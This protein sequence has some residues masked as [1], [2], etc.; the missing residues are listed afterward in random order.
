MNDDLIEINSSNNRNIIVSIIS[1]ISEKTGLTITTSAIVKNFSAIICFLENEGSLMYHK[2]IQRKEI[3]KNFRD[4]I[5]ALK[6]GTD[7]TS[8]NSYHFCIKVYELDNSDNKILFM[9]MVVSKFQN[10]FRDAL[11]YFSKAEN[12]LVDSYFSNIF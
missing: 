12:K 1:E 11:D 6:Q 3:Q 4:I 8:R 10:N 2:Q 9:R 7:S 5:S